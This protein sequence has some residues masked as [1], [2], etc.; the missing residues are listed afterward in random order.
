MSSISL[1]SYESANPAGK[2]NRS[3]TTTDGLTL[4]FASLAFFIQPFYVLIFATVLQLYIRIK[5]VFFLPMFCLSCALYWAGRNIGVTWDGGFD[6]AVGY[7]EIFQAMK[8]DTIVTLLQKYFATPAGN[9]IGYSTFV[10]L[11]SLFTDNERIF[12]FAIYFSMLVLLA[13]GAVRISSRY[14]LFIIALVFFGIGGFVEQAAL[15][16]FRA[17][18]ASLLLLVAISMYEM[19]RGRAR[20]LLLISCLFHTAVIPLVGFYIILV[21]AKYLR[22]NLALIIFSL[23]VV[24]ALKFIGTLI[25]TILLDSSRISYI[26][27][28]NILA[29]EVFTLFAIMV[30]YVFSNRSEI[31]VIYKF[32]FFVTCLLFFFYLL[33]PQY[34]FIAGRY[35]YMVQLFTSL[36]LFKTI[37]KIKFNPIICSILVVLFL[38]KMMTLNNSEFISGAFDNFSGVFSAPFFVLIN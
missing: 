33:L 16:L 18:L 29:A 9:E 26:N 22:S 1:H 24:I 30:L 7:V 14:Y 31:G 8:D 28:D 23:I 25:E 17:T 20:F 35:L 6:D 36:L 4:L 34:T 32:S 2:E 38:R 10:Y 27:T 5:P 12:L 15:H 21:H 13:F 19:D 11:I 37:M 3:I